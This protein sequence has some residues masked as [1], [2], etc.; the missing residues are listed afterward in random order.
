[1]AVPHRDIANLL[2][3]NSNSWLAR[4]ITPAPWVADALCAQVD[5]EMFFPSKSSPRD[6]VSEGPGNTSIEAKAVCRK[7]TVSAECLEYALANDEPHGIWGGLSERERRRLKK[8][9]H[10]PTDD[11]NVIAAIEI[12]YLAGD[13]GPTVARNLALPV[14]TVERVLHRS[15]IRRDRREAAQLRAQAARELEGGAA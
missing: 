15:G 5:P 14:N 3:P 6:S 2:A 10:L 13:S 8:P 7:C 1:M 9:N 12:A 4:F 11:P